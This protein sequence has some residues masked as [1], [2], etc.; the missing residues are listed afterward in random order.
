MPQDLTVTV[1]PTTRNIFLAKVLVVLLVGIA[2][3]LWLTADSAADYRKGQALTIE[4]YTANYQ[5]Y[6]AELMH[7]PGPTWVDIALCI[8][9][10]VGTFGIYEAAGHIRS[11]PGCCGK[12]FRTGKSP[13]GCDQAV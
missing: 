6:R 12:W 5:Q 4:E 7:E 8:V 10:A 2:V 11:S 9:L 13:H 1:S 3:G